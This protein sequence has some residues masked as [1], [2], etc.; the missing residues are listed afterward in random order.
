[1]EKQLDND[2]ITHPKKSMPRWWR[3]SPLFLMCF[4]II[5][6]FFNYLDRGIIPGA[7]SEFD[8]FIQNSREFD[9]D[10]KA[11]ALLGFLQS[12]FIV[13]MSISM[14]IFANLVH[15]WPPFRLVGIGL[16]IWCVSA[17]LA[18]TAEWLNSYTVLAI[19]RMLSG[20]G[21]GSFQV[22]AVPYIQDHANG[23]QGLWL[24]MYY[25]AIP[26]GTC[27]GY[28]YGALLA[29]SWP[30]AFWIEALCMIPA[31]VICF[32]LP[33]DIHV[34]KES[35]SAI[36]T[37]T[38]GRMMA[39]E[40]YNPILNTDDIGNTNTI[41]EEEH[42]VSSYERMSENPIAP[43]ML[44]EVKACLSRPI[45]VWSV[46]GYAAYSGGIIGFSTFGPQFLLGLGYFDDEFT[47]SIVFGGAMAAAGLFGTPL[48]GVISDRCLT[49]RRQRM[50]QMP[51]A[52]LSNTLN[53][54]LS[55][56]TFDGIATEC[57]D[58]SNSSVIDAK[59][60][61]PDNL[62]GLAG[63]NALALSCQA[64]FLGCC[65]VVVLC[66][67]LSSTIFLS[68]FS[69]AGLF[70]F[71]STST[72]NIAVLESVPSMHR[73]FAV[74]FSTLLMH[75]LGDVPSPI[76]IGSLKGTLAPDCTPTDDDKNDDLHIS[77]ECQDERD[78][79]RIVVAVIAIWFFLSPF[80]FG[81][82]WALATAKVRSWR[83]SSLLQ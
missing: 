45:F 4:F 3:P 24:G 1:M 43:T 60:Q 66:F 32:Y 10:T 83:L 41:M 23:K 12:S 73:G 13:G 22:V 79:L 26:F 62:D 20:V 70:F 35:D 7:A 38:N 55:S 77:D 52:N 37:D 76:I 69:L 74:G 53:E 36:K 81:V 49:R 34:D 75:A 27:V 19:A 28:G 67:P 25:T 63:V 33:R 5:T 14:P 48:G 71:S 31:V 51:D 72:M 29:H 78:D 47:A 57:P 56:A 65:A 21:E 46:L 2:W 68:V 30:W 40:P 17:F 44:V 64:N 59:G 58:S 50:M 61:P 16:S 8:G 39:G 9:D 11:D 42:G 15:S 80:S 54:R 82:G 18:G 6:N